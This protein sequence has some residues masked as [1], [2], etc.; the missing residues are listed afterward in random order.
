MSFT[1]EQ[2]KT[3]ATSV[4]FQNVSI[5]IP[6]FNEEKG[7]AQ[8]LSEL[9]SYD[10]LRDAEII[11]VDDGSTDY[12]AAIA[13]EF[14]GVT[15]VRHR[16]NRGYGS[17]IKSGAE[18]ATGDYIAWYDADSQHRPQDLVALLTKLITEDLDYC[19]GVRG[20]D[21]FVD[22]SRVLGKLVLKWVVG[23]L[24]GQAGDFNSGLRGFKKSVLLP[25][26]GLLPKRFGAST[27]TTVLMLENNHE[28]AEIP[29]TVRQ[30][31]GKSTVRQF[32]DGFQTIV[33]ILNLILLFRPMQIFGSI[34]GIFIGVGSLY[35]FAR[36][37]MH[38]GGI[39]TLA[40]IVIIF[41]IQILLFGILSGQISQLRRDSVEL[42]AKEREK[43]G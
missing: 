9:T 20:K 3:L 41:G 26:L 1:L 31:E 6:A 21:S 27:V 16:R 23:F 33:L 37:L 2:S 29:C 38:R 4:G 18:Y 25:Y 14:S 17:A 24:A 13:A 8:T 43:S 10:A 12:T 15:V 5:L 30:R 42:Q 7:L 28:G 39:P 34:G 11:V 36:A 22:K 19:I 35:G 40:A 32:R